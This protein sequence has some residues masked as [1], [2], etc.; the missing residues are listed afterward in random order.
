MPRGDDDDD[1]GDGEARWLTTYGD[2]MTLLL[3]F[4]VLLLSM[5]TINPQTFKVVISSFQ[6]AV[7]VLEGG[8][9]LSPAKLMN[10]GINVHELSEAESTVTQS[11]PKEVQKLLQIEEDSAKVRKDERGIVIQVTNKLLFDRG[12]IQL[13][14]EGVEFLGRVAM[15]LKAEGIQSRMVRVEGHTDNIPTT[16]YSSNWQISVLRA[17]NVV[18]VFT[19]NYNIDPSRMSAVGFGQTRPIASNETEEGR[20]ENRRVE[21]VILRDDIE[22][23]E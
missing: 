12:Q 11:I 9:T 7:G 22:N 21:I 15:L 20:Q 5:S 23:E 8:R 14:D 2:A 19:N 4:F 6:G 17:A 16:D 10:M 18:E 3:V 1:G 13:T